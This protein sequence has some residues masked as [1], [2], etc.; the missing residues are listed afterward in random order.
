EVRLNGAVVTSPGVKIRPGVDRLEVSGREVRPAAGPELTLLLHKPVEVVTTLRDPQGRRTVLDLLP[1]EVQARRPA[2]VGRLDYFSE[3]L[4]LLTTD[5]ELC[6]R[7]THP[8]RH[9]DKEYEVL[10][11]PPA[12]P[13]HLEA[14]RRGMTLAEGERLAPARV[15]ALAPDQGRQTLRLTLGQGLNRQIRRM[16]RDLGL[17][18]LR[19]RRVRQGPVRLGDLPPGAFRE[20]QPRELAAL[21]RAVGLEE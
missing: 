12:R 21:R 8:S 7:L 17:T 18:V 13:E 9:V 4:L 16:C 3:G 5:G 6:H 2:P 14:M 11:R 10:V 1:P 19:L 15:E 20:L